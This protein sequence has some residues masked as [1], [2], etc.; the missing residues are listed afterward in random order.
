MKRSRLVHVVALVAVA[1]ASGYPSAG[2][3]PGGGQQGGGPGRPAPDLY[4]G[5]P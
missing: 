5:S 3:A 1:V 2:A 4:A